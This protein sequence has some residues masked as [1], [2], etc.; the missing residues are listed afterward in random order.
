ML[1]YPPAIRPWRPTIDYGPGRRQANKGQASACLVEAAY[2]DWLD[3]AMRNNG[4]D[5]ASWHGDDADDGGERET[6]SD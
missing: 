3:R 6:A 5:S 2:L 4:D 1:A